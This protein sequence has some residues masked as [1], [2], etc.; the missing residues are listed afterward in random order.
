MKGGR[1]NT[2]YD[3]VQ[4]VDHI[5]ALERGGMHGWENLTAACS[6][7]N[8]RKGQLSL[9]DAL[10]RDRIAE[11][12]ANWATRWSPLEALFDRQANALQGKGI[13]G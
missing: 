5:V 7:C 13:N 4:A 3:C 11:D 9:L 12:H 1:I 6:S 8:C 2:C 10:M